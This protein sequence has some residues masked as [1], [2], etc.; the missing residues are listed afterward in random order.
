MYRSPTISQL[1]LWHSENSGDRKGGDNMVRHPCDSKAW[2]HFHDNID[3]T[4]GD[5]IPNFHFALAVD[6]VYMVFMVGSFQANVIHMVHLASD[7]FKLQLTAMVM[8]EKVFLCCWP[9]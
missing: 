9:Y 3:P 1:V 6:E 7:A 2:K 8:H 5:N 4:F